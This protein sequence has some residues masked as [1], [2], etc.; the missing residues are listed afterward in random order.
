MSDTRTEVMTAGA[1]FDQP[2]D[3]SRPPTLS[4]PTM[5]A[6]VPQQGSETDRA[7]A[8]IVTAQHCAVKRDM[9]R[10]FREI[11]ELANQAATDFYYEWTVKNRDGTRAVVSGPSIKCAMAVATAWGNCSVEAFPA[12]ETETHWTFMARFRDYE[13]GM[14][15]TRSFQQRKSQSLGG[16]MDQDRQRDIAFQIGQSKAIRNVINGVLG[17]FTARA[18]ASARNS[19]L[20]RA[21]ANPEGA[22]QSIV[23]I[24]RDLQI[25]IKLLERSVARPLARWEPDDLVKLFGR[26]RSVQDGLDT[27]EEVFGSLDD[28]EPAP[29]TAGQGG[30]PGPGTPVTGKPAGTRAPRGT[31]T[32]QPA[33]QP[34]ADNGGTTDP[35]VTTNAAPGSGDGQQTQAPVPPP[36]PPPAPPITNRPAAP[37]TI[38]P[39]NIENDP[40]LTVTPGTDPT[41]ELEF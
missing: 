30:D 39:P 2:F 14:T 38:P 9:P 17:M 34:P 7:M 23:R 13:K 33:T 12:N 35:P 27:V 37:P 21:Q 40:L 22:R 41:D 11:D 1:D 4:A 18:V 19:L 10:I 25:E 24:A 32:R 8:E 16:R 36:P 26:L 15:L 28:D 29:T 6:L 5:P 20:S 31:A 3:W